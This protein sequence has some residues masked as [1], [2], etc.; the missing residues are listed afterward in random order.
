[1][2]CQAEAKG[3]LTMD[4]AVVVTENFKE[5]GKTYKL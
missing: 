1:M 2:L 5:R 3:E 4:W